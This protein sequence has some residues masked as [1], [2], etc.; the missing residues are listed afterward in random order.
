MTKVKRYPTTMTPSR[1]ESVG[2][3]MLA[4][5]PPSEPCAPAHTILDTTLDSRP[6]HAQLEGLGGTQAAGK[7]RVCLEMRRKVAGCGSCRGSFGF[8]W[9]VEW[10]EIGDEE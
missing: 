2:I 8:A 4:A 1:K 10:L 7:A 9:E 6:C 5:Q 3:G